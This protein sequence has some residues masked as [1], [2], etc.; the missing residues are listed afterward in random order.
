[1]LFVFMAHDLIG[2]NFEGSHWF[3]EI[4]N[5]HKLVYASGE[6]RW[7]DTLWQLPA[8]ISLNWLPAVPFNWN[9][10]LLS[11]SYTLHPL[12]STFFCYLIVKKEK[13]AFLY[14]TFPLLSMAT[15]VSVSLPFVVGIVNGTI[16]IFWPLFFILYFKKI[17]NIIYFLI[18][19]VL[20][21]LL[22]FNYDVAIVFMPLL[23]FAILQKSHLK[24]SRSEGIFIGLIMIAT[25]FQV[26]RL[27]ERYIVA[28]NDMFDFWVSLLGQANS[29]HVYL[30]QLAILFAFFIGLKLFADFRKPAILLVSF[31]ICCRLGV[32]W[33][34]DSG[35]INLYEARQ[36]RSASFVIAWGIAVGLIY[37]KKFLDETDSKE[38]RQYIISCSIVC[39]I[40]S[41]IFNF[42]CL[43]SWNNFRSSV[44]SIV[45][46]E[47][48]CVFVNQQTQIKDSAY[49]SI[50]LQET[51]SPQSILLTAD[52]ACV[53]EFE[54][55]CQK[56]VAQKYPEFKCRGLH[57]TEYKMDLSATKT[58]TKKKDGP[59]L[60]AY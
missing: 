18:S 24:P 15:A 2:L 11:Y 35:I 34:N 25:H 43:Q 47:K 12:L 27:T 19:T 52:Q 32:Y 22:S 57:L 51:K 53:K 50:L 33:F 14:M 26:Y 1:M 17:E 31:Y 38:L 6:W 48:G 3:F 37:L 55:P 41:L 8:Y 30:F 40:I 59:F 60:L 10:H 58:K 23:V 36:N 5:Q 13:N 7:S 46:E 29:S 4:L 39:I 54:D 20:L 28:P 49:I 16:S 21:V 9:L 45:S 56:Y 44:L 42:K